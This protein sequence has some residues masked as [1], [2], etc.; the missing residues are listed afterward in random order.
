M[1]KN[2]KNKPAQKPVKGKTRTGPD[3]ALPL[4]TPEPFKWRARQDWIALGIVLVVAL[5]L[6]LVFF[7][8]NKSNNPVFYYPIMDALYHHEW[9]EQ[10]LSGTYHAEDVYFR[11][12]L[13]PYLLAFLYKISGSS[14]S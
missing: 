8:L 11:G 3:P 2:K 10:I 7:F 1:A 4:E 14:T 12:P 6:R 5:S 9:A 13:Y